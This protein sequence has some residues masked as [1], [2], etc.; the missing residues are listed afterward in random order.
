MNDIK[1]IYEDDNIKMNIVEDAIFDS[2][3]IYPIYEYDSI[4][5]NDEI[6]ILNCSSNIIKLHTQN[7]KIIKI[8]KKEWDSGYT[9]SD[10]LGEYNKSDIISK[11]SYSYLILQN[12]AKEAKY[13]FVKDRIGILEHIG[14]I[15]V[16][17]EL[18]YEMFEL[19][20]NLQGIPNKELILELM[21]ENTNLKKY[22]PFLDEYVKDQDLEEEFF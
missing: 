3:L 11:G 13:N 7:D 15:S 14:V 6:S 1:F 9:D 22:I 19:D 10:I 8:L 17:N 16:D 20:Q 21:N 2:N 18:K 4:K 12:T 5:Y